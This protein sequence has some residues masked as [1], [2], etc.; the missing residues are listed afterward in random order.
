[1]FTTGTIAASIFSS[2][3]VD[4][5]S[6]IVLFD[7]PQCGWVTDTNSYVPAVMSAAN[8]Q[9]RQCYRGHEATEP[10]DPAPDACQDYLRANIT[11]EVQKAACPFNSTM[12]KQGA[13]VSMDMGL[14]DLNVA[15]GSNLP[16]NDRI[17]FRRRTTCAPLSLAGRTEVV[18]WNDTFWSL[19]RFKITPGEEVAALFYSQKMGVS[20]LKKRLQSTGMFDLVQSNITYD[21]SIG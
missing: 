14:L 9:V 13:A 16:E 1:L 10:M 5:S 2:L 4:S 6:L 3:V 19:S 8:N 17:K 12:C 11:S 15:Y 21:L 7:S 20:T 18:P